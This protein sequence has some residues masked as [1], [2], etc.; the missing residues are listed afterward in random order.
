MN[1]V[2]VF[3]EKGQIASELG[4]LQK[5]NKHQNVIFISSE[6]ANFLNTITVE[7]VLNA[8]QPNIVINTS[9]YTLVDMAEEE[10]DKCMQINASTVGVIANWCKL[11]SATLI[12]F[13][14]DYVFDGTSTSEYSETDPTSPINFYGKSKLKG[15]QLIQDSGLKNYF[16][17]RTSWICSPYSSNFV[18]TML[19]LAKER[20]ILNVVNDQFGCPTF[21]K[22]IALF[23]FQKLNQFNNFPSGIYNLTNSG[24]TTWYLFAEKI[25]QEANSFELYNQEFKLRQLGSISS[26]QYKTKAKRPKNSK[27]SSKKFTE[28]FHYLMPSWQTSLNQTIRGILE[29]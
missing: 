27:L 24:N 5:N 14:T 17:F 7:K 28:T 19:K 10:N 3:G 21:A 12:H 13:S 25:F 18:K 29:V 23:V 2:L 8:E 15:E 11:N 9:A 6:R 26:D 22:D 1:K 4:Q 16:I 20:E